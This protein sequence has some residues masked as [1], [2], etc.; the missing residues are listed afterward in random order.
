MNNVH[1][2]I[3]EI[4][5]DSLS[6]YELLR[7]LV[8]E[9]N[10]VIENYN[11][12]PD[13]IAEEVKNLDASQLFSAVLDQL[14]DTIATDNTKSV[15]AVK[16]YKKHDL[17]YATFN[18]TVNLYESLIDFST[19]ETT[20]LIPGTNIREVNI[21]ELFIEVRKLIDDE[22]HTRERDDTTLQ[23]NINAETS[24]RERAD[25]T[26]QTKID[27]EEQART[28]ADQVLQTN[29]D[30]EEQARS[31]ADTALQTKID[32]EVQARSQA[33]AALQT[34]IDNDI[35]TLR[36]MLSS[37]YNFKGDVSSISALPETGNVNDTYYVQDVKYKVTWT[38]SA[39]VQS[40]LSEADY[41]TEL[42]EL[43]GDLSKLEETA[44]LDTLYLEKNCNPQG[45]YKADSII[46]GL[47]FL[48]KNVPNFIHSINVECELTGNG[49]VKLDIL[50]FS[51][52]EIFSTSIEVTDYSSGVKR[53]IFNVNDYILEEKI[54]IRIYSETLGIG[55]CEP[56]SVNKKVVDTSNTYA[57]Y[58]VNENWNYDSLYNYIPYCTI[59]GFIHKKSLFVGTNHKFTKIKDAVDYA[60]DHI[61]NEWDIFIES[62]TYDIYSEFGGD[63]WYSAITSS[64][65]NMQGLSLGNNINI[66][67]IGNVKLTLNA[68]DNIATS[69]NVPNLSVIELPNKNNRIENI[70]IECKN[71]RYG[72]HDETDGLHSN[73]KRYFKNIE[74]THNGVVRGTWE[75]A[76]SYGC[77]S[78]DN[79]YFEYENCKFN[80]G[81]LAHQSDKQT[82]PPNFIATNCTFNGDSYAISLNTS[83]TCKANITFNNC[84]INYMVR[85]L[86]NSDI[87][88]IYGSGNNLFNY[89]VVGNNKINSQPFKLYDLTRIFKNI[90]NSK[91]TKGNAVQIY[92]NGVSN[93]NDAKQ[94]IGIA[95][96]DAEQ[97]TDVRVQLKG[98][99]DCDGIA[100]FSENN[101]LLGVSNGVIIENTSNY[102]GIGV[103]VDDIK[104]IYLF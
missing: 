52:N 53:L 9:M 91:I 5:G 43:N 41:Q 77:G 15:N 12:I 60:N 79:S 21:S 17:L 29:I 99:Y 84:E 25:T 50:D 35:N 59:T 11:T 95:L 1:F 94:I 63:A 93:G 23:Q 103:Y 42:S 27:N 81:W 72:I 54:W 13:Q 45:Y 47:G 83:G 2:A 67:G 31:Q 51:R 56:S 55:R 32:N 71:V 6:Y 18:E 102:F 22:T 36:T 90:G 68:P 7:K 75:S 40:S 8:K 80:N 97:N 101:T 26:L 86:E 49:I 62:G 61:N 65:G 44:N 70:N 64:K 74:I 4:Y 78:S 89:V 92:K 58:L 98:Y 82:I 34:K 85:L 30:N 37:P 87:W 39:W 10:A 73:S 38:G 16:V 57:A 19:G 28:Q 3:P 104:Q 48:M 88:S 66:I 20:E 96:N 24:A 46:H 69:S 76:V 14:I 33:D 100:P